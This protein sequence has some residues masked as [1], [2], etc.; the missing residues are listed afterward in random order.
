MWVSVT[1]RHHIVL[2]VA[3][4]TDNEFLINGT[5]DY[6]L[7]NEKD[8]TTP[9]AAHMVFE[10]FSIESPKMKYYQVYLDS[11]QAKDALK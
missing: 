1:K 8:L 11:S 4:I 3:Q 10:D 7:I 2:N 9:W 6:R 5:V